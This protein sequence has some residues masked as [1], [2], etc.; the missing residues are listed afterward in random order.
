M[1]ATYFGYLDD[2]VRNHVVA[3]SRAVGNMGP[4]ATRSSNDP[5]TRLVQYDEATSRWKPSLDTTLTRITENG[6][7]KYQ[8]TIAAER[9]TMV[10]KE[11]LDNPELMSTA[12][13]EMYELPHPGE[14][15]DARWK[16]RLK[17]VPSKNGRVWTRYRWENDN[18]GGG[19]DYHRGLRDQQW[20]WMHHFT[21]AL[22]KIPSRVT[23]YNMALLFILG[24]M[25]YGTWHSADFGGSLGGVVYAAMDLVT[26][27]VTSG[28]K[29][30]F[31]A[32]GQGAWTITD[33]STTNTDANTTITGD[34]S[35]IPAFD[36]YDARI[37]GQLGNVTL[38]V[39][40]ETMQMLQPMLDKML[41]VMNPTD[42]MNFLKAVLFSR[43]RFGRPPRTPPVMRMTRFEMLLT[44]ARGPAFHW[45][46]LE[47]NGSHRWKIAA[48]SFADRG[49]IGQFSAARR[50]TK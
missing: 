31:S 42:L 17:W 43:R 16:G 30:V 41:R 28:V 15:N 47:R 12:L 26:W 34:P 2:D 24:V 18:N 21:A 19:D 49:S 5:K 40:K 8:L 37:K 48:V 29:L 36:E 13:N 22:W 27:M 1:S 32:F 25:A 35:E 46:F 44:A 4:R 14:C 10:P 39:T 50:R 38:N 20:L 45:R 33:G 9:F 23:M 3:M 11:L 6:F 7:E